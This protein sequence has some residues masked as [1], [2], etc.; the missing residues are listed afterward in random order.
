MEE[1]LRERGVSAV[2]VE[3]QQVLA[4]LYEQALG[5]A[6]L[7]GRVSEVLNENQEVGL[8]RDRIQVLPTSRLP[9]TPSG[10]LDRSR[11]QESVKVL[12]GS[13]PTAAGAEPPERTSGPADRA[14]RL[15][16]IRSAYAQ[17]LPPGT[18]IRDDRSFSQL[19]GDSLSY[20]SVSTRL[21]AVLGRLPGDWHLLSINELG[22]REPLGAKSLD[23]STVLR[24]VAILVVVSSHIGL[25]DVRGGA[26]LLLAV[27]GFNFARFQL[28]DVPL[29]RRRRNLASS[30]M[31]LLLPT[32][33]WLA[34]LA[35]FVAEYSPVVVFGLNLFG[36]DSG[37]EWR[38]WFIEAL[39][40][41]VL[42][43][44]LLMSTPLLDRWQRRR[45]SWFAVGVLGVGLAL[46]LTA[47]RTA[48]GSGS[49]YTPVLV[50]WLFGLGWLIATARSRPVKLLIGVLA[51]GLCVFYF[52]G[53]LSRQLVVA[54]GL[55]LLIS[56]PAIPVPR[57]V[58]ATLSVLA[59][60]SLFIYL[61]HYQV[62]PIFGDQRLAGLLASVFFGF[63]CWY[64][65]ERVQRVRL[66]GPIRL[67]GRRATA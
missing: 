5:S 2:A 42:G 35:V 27:A 55:V 49:M 67:G 60:A 14:A 56:V 66:P 38:Y 39:A 31:R 28:S 33:L 13:M 29:S 52:D 30:F 4:V 15:A 7:A 50:A 59:S 48:T 65:V 54:G 64:A 24:A 9:R 18:L 12:F 53:S 37:P 6:S 58:A 11:A 46:L 41:L 17:A 57:P 44:S 63:L 21:G 26:H 23:T 25:T 22:G 47:E 51:V 16:A 1:L 3:H 40:F 62:Y 20:V 45:P 36:P 8:P 43:A 61:T 32:A 10:K 34:V 19:G